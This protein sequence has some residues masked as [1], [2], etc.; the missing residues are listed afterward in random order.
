MKAHGWANEETEERSLLLPKNVYT[1]S[2]STKMATAWP[3]RMYRTC[4]QNGGCNSDHLWTYLHVFFL[5]E[6]H[7]MEALF[8]TWYQEIATWL[9][10]T[11]PWKCVQKPLRENNSKATFVQKREKLGLGKLSRSQ[12]CSWNL[13][14]KQEKVSSTKELPDNW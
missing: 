7:R 14:Q 10:L 5:T 13:T 4:L 3:A 6:N 12:K 11:F 8:T 1:S 2:Q 9:I